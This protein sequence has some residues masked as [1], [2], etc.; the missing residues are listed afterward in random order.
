MTNEQIEQLHEKNQKLIDMVIQRAKR[1]FP[2]DIALI[3]L[4]GSFSTDDFHAHSD[5]D[6]IIVNNNGNGW[7]IGDCFILDEVGYDI[8]CTPW[9]KLEEMA[10]LETP[11]LSILTDLKILYVADE[12]HEKRFKELQEKA[13]ISLAQPLNKDTIARAKIYLDN[14]KRIFTD[15]IL[16]EEIGEIRY[17]ASSL[18]YEIVN[19]VVALNN[20]YIKRGIK[21]YFDDLP[22]YEYVPKNF[23]ANFEAIVKAKN[24]DKI[25]DSAKIF[26]VETVA[27]YKKL[28][29]TIAQIPTP[30]KENLPC[31]YEEMWC[32]CRNKIINATTRGDGNYAFLAGEGAQSYFDEMTV[33]LG[34]PKQDL[35]Q[36]FAVDD[37]D[38][39]REKF[40]EIM[41]EYQ[42]LYNELGISVRHFERFDDLYED[43]MKKD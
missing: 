22:E 39:F 26:L 14:A 27:L 42:Q 5:L 9:E 17:Q 30:T 41:D 23:K 1:D 32:N 25:K 43:Y 29:Q 16:A 36:H 40:L 20:T 4:T 2:D 7:N 11:Y 18:V 37:L 19:T 12:I 10:R 35:M 38:D 3:G 6:L 33:K 15:I 21:R 24:E 34:T 13:L 8:Y 28:E 31:W